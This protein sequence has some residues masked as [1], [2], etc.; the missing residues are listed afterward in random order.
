MGNITV[1]FADGF[2]IATTTGTLSYDEVSAAFVKY[3][4]LVE[5]HIIVNMDASTVIELSGEQVRA[6]PSVA[7]KH[8]VNRREGG[9]TAFVCVH[10]HQFGL[11]RM[12]SISSELAG[13]TY[14]YNTFKTLAEALGWL[15][16]V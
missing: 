12:Y 5:L 3:G 11:S 16:E 6:L 13:S 14:R 8:L 9:R 7:Q 2:L 15:Q 10:D 1:E 4:P